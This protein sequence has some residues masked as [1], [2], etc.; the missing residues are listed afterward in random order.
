MDIM[1]K[2]VCHSSV[3]FS[4]TTQ[5][6]FDDFIGKIYVRRGE[7]PP[8]DHPVQLLMPGELST[9]LKSIVA[10]LESGELVPP[11]ASQA[12]SIDEAFAWKRALRYCPRGLIDL[13]NSRARR[14]TCSFFIFSLVRSTTIARCNYVQRSP[15][16]YPM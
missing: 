9:L 5:G 2:Q 10:N 4:S 15:D 16:A 1:S 7:R 14:G 13:V 11:S 12:Q 8:A 6:P 3:I